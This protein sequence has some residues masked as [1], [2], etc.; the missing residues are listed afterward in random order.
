MFEWFSTKVRTCQNQGTVLNDT[1]LECSRM[2][3]MHYRM[4]Q[5]RMVNGY[6]CLDRIKECV[7]GLVCDWESD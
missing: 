1:T 4:L 5:C 7:I 3:M 6:D 2:I